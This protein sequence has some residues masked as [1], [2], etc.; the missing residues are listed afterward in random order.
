MTKKIK[1]INGISIRGTGTAADGDRGPQG[2]K[3]VAGSTGP[4]GTTGA[5]GATGGTGSKGDTGAAGS[6]GADGAVSLIDELTDV[7]TT[8]GSPT[9]NEVLKWDGSNWVPGTAG[10]TSEFTFSIDSFSD[11]ISDTSQLIG[12]GGK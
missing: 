4:R 7:D 8:T 2:Q 6:D 12:D 3:G 11:A 9:L 5:A 10:D 1:K